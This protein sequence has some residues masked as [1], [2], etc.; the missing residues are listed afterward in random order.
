MV[1]GKREGNGIKYEKD[2]SLF[3]GSWKNNK[4]NGIGLSP[5][6]K[7]LFVS[8]YGGTNV[9]SFMRRLGL[10][11]R[12][13]LLRFSTEK[14]E[15]FWSALVRELGIEWSTPFTQVLDSSRGVEW[16]RWLG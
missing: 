1:N 14:P 11:S 9:W 8:E 6:G 4:P 10:K 7:F 2:G 16:C 12:D 15:E 3:E 13:E 5:D